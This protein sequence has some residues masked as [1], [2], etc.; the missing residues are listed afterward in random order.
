M[1]RRAAFLA[2]FLAGCV[3]FDG[4]GL[5]IDL[6]A[7]TALATW[8]GV[9]GGGEDDFAALMTQIV[10]GDTLLQLFPR[11]TVV[12][13]SVVQ[14]GDA[15]NVELELSFTDP[16][17]MGVRSWNDK[18]PYR[19]CPQTGMVITAAN[20]DGRDADGCVV[21]RRGVKVLRADFAVQPR[22]QQGSL[23]PLHQAWVEAGRPEFPSE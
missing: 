21:W 11:A 20:A 6:K 19:L 8:K 18:H 12:G 2:I 1:S 9:R 17:Q 16:S 10:P 4:M 23:L 22:S 15:L 14:T 13:R 3:E 7:G 5:V